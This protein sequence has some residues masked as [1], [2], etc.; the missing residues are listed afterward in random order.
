MLN[1]NNSLTV[2][3]DTDAK[4]VKKFHGQTDLRVIE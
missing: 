1:F 2:L 3:Q 4:N